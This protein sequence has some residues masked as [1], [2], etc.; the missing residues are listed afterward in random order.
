MLI[1]TNGSSITASITINNEQRAAQFINSNPEYLSYEGNLSQPLYCYEYVDGAV[2]LKDGW[3]DI[4]AARET[5][6]IDVV[7]TLEAA[8]TLQLEIIN[9]ER[10]KVL[11]AGVP[12]VVNGMDDVIQTRLEDRV[13]LMALRTEAEE[14]RAA[15]EMDAVMAF[16]GE[17]N[18]DH[19]VTPQEMINIANA[20]LAHIKLIYAE[21]W[22]LKD[23]IDTSSTVEE[24]KAVTW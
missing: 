22:Q 5:L 3:E 12:Y 16:R 14:R 19:A 21:S 4:K 23:A 17:N 1:K 18:T 15:G 8:K 10:D 24:V 2:R 6:G 9:Q 11:N 13:N 20:A 7:T